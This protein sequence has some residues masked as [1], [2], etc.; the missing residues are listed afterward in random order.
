MA[1]QH[2]HMFHTNVYCQRNRHFCVHYCERARALICALCQFNFCMLCLFIFIWTLMSSKTPI[3]GILFAT[4]TVF[5]CA[6]MELHKLHQAPSS[7]PFKCSNVQSS[8]SIWTVSQRRTDFYIYYDYY[9]NFFAF[10]FTSFCFRF[11]FV[12]FYMLHV[13]IKATSSFGSF[14]ITWTYI[15]F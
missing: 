13:Y 15:N 11:W 12:L 3:Y 4:I 10:H 14:I 7:S 5:S 1:T 9:Y 6:P 8:I 2:T